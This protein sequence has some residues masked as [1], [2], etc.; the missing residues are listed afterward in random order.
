MPFTSGTAETPSVLLKAMN[1]H[2]VANGWTKLRGEED[3]AVAG[4]KA[5]RYWRILVFE[6]Q[7]TADD[8]VGMTLLHLKTTIGGSNVATVAAN[9][10][11]SSLG[12]GT[13]ALLISGGAVRSADIDDQMWSAVYDFGTATTIR[14]VTMKADATLVYCP[15]DFLIQ[16]SQD[17]KCW[18]TIKRCASTTWAAS[19]TKNFNWTDGVVDATHASANGPRRTGKGEWFS[20]LA[21]VSMTDTLADQADDIWIW[22]GPGYDAARRVYIHARGHT[23]NTL[24]TYIIEWGV[25]IGYNPSAILWDDHP[26]FSGLVYERSHLMVNTT[27]NYWF[28][29]NSKRFILVTRSGAQDYTSSFVGFLSAFGTPDQYPF[30]LA[31]FATAG[32]VTAYT[33]GDTNNRLS[34]CADPG[35]GAAF[36]R[37]WDGT[38][39]APN[40]RDDAVATNLFSAYPATSWVW[41]VHTGQGSRPVHPQGWTGDWN[42]Y[43]GAH[44]FDY[45]VATRQ[46]ELP[47]FPCIVQH[48]PYGNVGALDGVFAIPSGGILSPLAILT[49]SGQDYRIFPNRTR[50]NGVNFFAIRED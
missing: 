9:W 46:S 21:N 35:V 26:G 20:R 3:M 29:S 17:G 37:L 48:D 42:D 5:A 8:F 50:R 7:G 14:E 40:N 13:T 10:T 11:L 49:I 39:I 22:Q 15:R 28:Y 47:L 4:P 16:W 45:F 1:T 34:S 44:F 19:E 32:S 18:T 12:T 25:S 2:L 23:R 24:S 43:V 6:T 33:Y 36:V 27:V 31:I 41:P 30:P 38:T